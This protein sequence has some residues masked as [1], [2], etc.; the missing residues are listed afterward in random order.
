MQPRLLVFIL[1]ASCFL[2]GT[3]QV[4]DKVNAEN[5]EEA[6]LVRKIQVLVDTPEEFKAI[7]TESIPVLEVSITSSPE[8]QKNHQLH[9]VTIKLDNSAVRLNIHRNGNQIAAS[10]QVDVNFTITNAQKDALELM[11]INLYRFSL[12]NNEQDHGTRRAKPHKHI[13]LA[14]YMV[15]IVGPNEVSPLSPLCGCSMAPSF[16]CVYQLF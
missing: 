11:S 5:F 4:P 12:G 6:D 14:A 2:Q 7:S 3:S 13:Q 8:K 15:S 10:R 1:V 9:T 16:S